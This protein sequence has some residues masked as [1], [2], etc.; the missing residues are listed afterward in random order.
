MKHPLPFGALLLTLACASPQPAVGQDLSA[1]NIQGPVQIKTVAATEGSATRLLTGAAQ[2]DPKAARAALKK[3]DLGKKNLALD[4]Y[5]PV[6][7]FPKFGGKPAKGSKS[8]AH[9]HRGVLYRFCLL[10]T[11]PSPRDRTRSRMP[12]SA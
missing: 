12:S 8:I 2:A 1:E 9:T 3:Y 10:Y 4:G 7:Y 11:S 5:D 6:A